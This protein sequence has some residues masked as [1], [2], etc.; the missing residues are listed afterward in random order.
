MSRN[1]LI[2]GV[3]PEQFLTPAGTAISTE[4]IATFRTDVT[5]VLAQSEWFVP[6]HINWL[7]REVSH[8]LLWNW[9]FL[10]EWES[11]SE[12]MELLQKNLEDAIG[13]EELFTRSWELLDFMKSLVL[14]YGGI[15]YDNL[16]W[17]EDGNPEDTNG[18]NHIHQSSLLS[19]CL[20]L[21]IRFDLPKEILE[22]WKVKLTDS[23]QREV[24]ENI[25]PKL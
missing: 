1:Y 11:D 2:P 12:K 16:I 7:S 18:N 19:E 10:S 21:G 20:I 8:Q 17:Y 5:K 22:L 4:L 24:N 14:K 3:P 9:K 6:V 13:K 15:I 23:D 25:F